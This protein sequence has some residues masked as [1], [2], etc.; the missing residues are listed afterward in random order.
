[1]RG[2]IRL[3][4]TFSYQVIFMQMDTLFLM[5]PTSSQ[6]MEKQHLMEIPYG[7][8]LGIIPPDLIFT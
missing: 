1:M 5:M 3:Q 4:I 6:V 2:Q 8:T 7:T